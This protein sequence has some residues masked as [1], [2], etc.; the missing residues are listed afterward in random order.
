[1]A[2]RLGYKDKISWE[3]IQ[4]PYIPKGMIDSM[5]QQQQFQAGQLQILQMLSASIPNNANK[6]RESA[7]GHNE[8]AAC[9]PK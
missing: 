8:N 7:N 1:M 9:N 3:T 5:N 2:K 6:N 4:N